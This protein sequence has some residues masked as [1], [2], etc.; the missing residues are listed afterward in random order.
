MKLH[1]GILTSLVAFGLVALWGCA[2]DDNDILV[3]EGTSLE[4][5]TAQALTAEATRAL[6]FFDATISRPVVVDGRTAIPSGA[7]LRGRLIDVDKP[8]PGNTPSRVTLSFQEVVSPDGTTHP[9]HTRPVHLE[10]MSDTIPAG[11]SL[12]VE[13][14]RSMEV[15]VSDQES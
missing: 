1:A 4:V 12:R 10:T 2:G 11:R 9:V 15:K 6:E 14:S 13:L 5:T 8:L 7:T 3:P